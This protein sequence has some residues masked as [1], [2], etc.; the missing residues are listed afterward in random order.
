MRQA[1]FLSDAKLNPQKEL[2]MIVHIKLQIS[3]EIDEIEET[4]KSTEMNVEMSEARFHQFI[5]WFRS[6][7][8]V[9]NEANDPII[10]TGVNLL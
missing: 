10:C 5:R 6:S 8:Q 2:K 3:A 1:Y 9:E 4:K 7:V